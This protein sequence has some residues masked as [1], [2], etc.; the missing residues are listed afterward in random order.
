M[1]SRP[2]SLGLTTVLVCFA[3]GAAGLPSACGG[4]RPND[5]ACTVT[6]G[7][8][9]TNQNECAE[10]LPYPCAQGVCCLLHEA[11]SP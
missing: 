7:T 11:G 6:G 1:S 10:S 9:L 2:T 4:P 3:A 8:C 5:D